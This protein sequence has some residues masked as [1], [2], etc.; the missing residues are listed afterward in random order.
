MSV[1]KSPFFK[2]QTK[3]RLFKNSSFGD[4]DCGNHELALCLKHLLPEFRSVKDADEGFP[5]LSSFSIFSHIGLKFLRRC[6]RSLWR[7]NSYTCF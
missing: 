5:S 1:R 4:T 2:K 7:T 3:K 6:R